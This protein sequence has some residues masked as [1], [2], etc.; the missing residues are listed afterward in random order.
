MFSQEAFSSSF[1][2][3]IKDLIS[4]KSDSDCSLISLSEM[5]LLGCLNSKSFQKTEAVAAFQSR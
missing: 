5:S 4:L 3:S 1:M 2:P